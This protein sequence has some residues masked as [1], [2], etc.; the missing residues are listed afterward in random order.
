MNIKVIFAAALGMVALSFAACSDDESGIL[1]GPPDYML[2]EKPTKGAYILT[3][4]GNDSIWGQ[5]ANQVYVDLSDTLQQPILSRSWHLGF[6]CGNPARVTL[7]Q[8]LSR[9]YPTGKTEF[10]AV[11]EADATVE[12][13][14]DLAGGMMSFPQDIAITDA[15]DGDLEKTM[16]GDLST[17]AAESEV[18]LLGE[19]EMY[20]VDWYK[21]KITALP[22]GYQMEYGR[23]NDTTPKQ[24][25]IEKDAARTFVAFSL[26]SGKIVEVPDHWDLMWA[27]SIAL[28][29]MPNGKQILG[30]S[31]DVITSNRVGG[32]EVAQV[33]VVNPKE[34]RKEFENF[35]KADV[36]NLE[37]TK[38]ADL[39]GT[40]WRLSPMPNAV[41][42]GPKSDRFYVFKDA[43]DNYFKLRFLHFCEADGGVRGEPVLEAAPLN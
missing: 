35:A 18:F 36:A 34:I 21:V 32:V 39:L 33:M 17:N 14:P 5:H 27:K 26:H 11:S 2:E 15:T 41:A 20:T 6:Y 13:F 3:L 16:F 4:H 23:I 9:V 42:P 19:E 7:N 22:E 10:A 12:G 43:E 29:T 1:P 8:S 24:V 31:S 37:F 28:T 25:T 30:P 38:N 40:D